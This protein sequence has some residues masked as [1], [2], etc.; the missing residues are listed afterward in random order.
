MPPPGQPPV[1]FVHGIDDTVAI[2]DAMRARLERDGLS[3]HAL[4]MTPPG[5]QARLEVLA[6]QLKAFIHQHLHDRT[7]DLVGFS[8]GGLICR[9]YLQRLNG[10]ARVRRL[11]TL[12]SPH[13]GTLTAFMCNRPGCLQMR[14]GSSFLNDLNSDADTLST[15]GFTSVYTPTDLMILPASSSRLP[16]ARNMAVFVLFHGLVVRHPRMIQVVH[17]LLLK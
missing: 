5:G 12:C 13:N 6:A 11:I 10:L 7:F 4:T 3:T 16:A 9:Y 14:P 1:L 15:V 8:M 2:F 17:A